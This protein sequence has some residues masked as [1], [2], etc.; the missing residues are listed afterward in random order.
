[1][2]RVLIPRADVATESLSAALISLGW[3]VE[4]ITAFRTVRAA[5]PPPAIRDAIKSGGFD[6]VLFSS[7][8]T[9]RNLVGI[10]G[11]PHPTTVIACIGEQT[12]AAARDMG[13]VV[14]VLPEETTISATIESLIAHGEKLRLTAI[15]NGDVVWRPSVKRLTR[16]RS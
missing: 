15:E 13:L 1:M 4:E 2:N 11:K 10:A 8:S 12:A 3:E 7:A 16:K 6:A 14:E 5:P 9:V